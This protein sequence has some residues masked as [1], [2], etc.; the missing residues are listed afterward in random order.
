MAADGPGDSFSTAPVVTVDDADGT[1]GGSGGR[2]TE[3]E[4]EEERF[5]FSVAATTLLAP[6]PGED[7]FLT[8]WDIEMIEIMVGKRKRNPI[9][10]H[11]QW[12]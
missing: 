1:G 12:P 4:E 6:A 2:G 8:L 10:I 11:H 9:S 5:A 3:E 7:S